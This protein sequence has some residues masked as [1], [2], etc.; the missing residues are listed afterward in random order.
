MKK[1]KTVKKKKRI[2]SKAKGSSAERELARLLTEHFGTPFA[3]VGVSSGARV[4]NTKLPNNAIGVMTGDLIVPEGFRFSIEVKA[5]NVTVD[6]LDRSALLDK[7]LT[8]VSDDADSVGKIPMLCWKRNRKGWIVAFLPNDSLEQYYYP[9][10]YSYYRGW[11]VCR[12][13][14]LLGCITDNDK[15]WFTDEC[16]ERL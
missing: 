8:Q 15:F 16:N 1:T 3:R 4:K 12:L 13:D 6:L 9:I 2:N 7:F 14:E 10:Y 5:V 11:M